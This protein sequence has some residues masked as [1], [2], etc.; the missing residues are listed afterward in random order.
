MKVKLKAELM[1]EA[2]PILFGADPEFELVS[3]PDGV[4][5]PAVDFQGRLALMGVEGRI[6]LDGSGRQVEFRPDPGRDGKELTENFR[7]LL[8]SFYKRVEELMTEGQLVDISFAGHRY[9]LGGH[10][11][12]GNVQPTFS[13]IRLLDKLLG[14]RLQDLNGKARLHNGYGRLGDFRLQPHG[15]EYRVPPASLFA[16][17]ETL[18]TFIDIIKKITEKAIGGI[19]YDPDDPVQALADKIGLDL[20]KLTRLTRKIRQAIRQGDCKACL[21][22]DFWGYRLKRPVVSFRFSPDLFNPGFKDQ[23]IAICGELNDELKS[24]L[25]AETGVRLYFG[26][27]KADRGLVNS[28]PLAGYEVAKEPFSDI[29]YQEQARLIIFPVYFCRAL[30]QQDSLSLDLV[31]E[32]KEKIANTVCDF[33]KPK[34][35]GD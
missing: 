28:I 11:H 13:F 27:Y 31:R 14:R 34:L 9:P 23:L 19:E 5:V 8:D 26:G 25:P 18:T 32:I 21:L 29:H 20:H 17:P 33:I 15:T 3:I 12:I 10:V 2:A 35:I 22:S 6:G 30:R 4:V 1:N 16:G 24:V 7:A